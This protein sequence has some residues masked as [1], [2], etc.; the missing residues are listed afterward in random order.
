MLKR[1]TDN[2]F[3]FL[4][5][6]L[7]IR[8][9]YENISHKKMPNFKE[10]KKFCKSSPY[11]FWYIIYDNKIK[12]GTAYLS[13]LD[14]IAIHFLPNFKKEINYT[15]ILKILIKKHPKSRYLVNISNKNKKLM[16]TYMKNKFKLIQYTFELQKK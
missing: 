1:V 11:Q 16:K 3:D 10:H 12:M 2:D 5:E 15:K 7:K 4:Y 6:I 13:K 9:S 14:E 8:E